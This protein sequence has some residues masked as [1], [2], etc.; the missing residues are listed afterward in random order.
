[1]AKIKG[2]FA[3]EKF[4]KRTSNQEKEAKIPEGGLFA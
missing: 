3:S 4:E 2:E 1:V